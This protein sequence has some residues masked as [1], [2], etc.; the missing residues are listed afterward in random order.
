MGPTRVRPSAGPLDERFA[1]T[2]QSD[3]KKPTAWV[4]FVVLASVLLCISGAFNII[5]GLVAVFSDK[6]FVQGSAQT[7]V[8][9][10]TGWGWFHIFLG[11]VLFATGLALYTGATWA[12]IT[13]IIVVSVNMVTQ[14][15]EM[16]A[17]PLWSLVIVT[18]DLLIIWAVIVH[19]DE[20]RD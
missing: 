2:Q 5:T 4:G 16:P 9:D 20:I 3:Y 18:V 1:M 12:R 19:G 17:Y 11:I 8:L 7:V 15:M 13:A 14:L 10:V 6:I